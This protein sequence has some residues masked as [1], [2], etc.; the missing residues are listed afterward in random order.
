VVIQIKIERK[1][2]RWRGVV[3]GRVAWHGRPSPMPS[4]NG[5]GNCS[6]VQTDRTRVSVCG[7][8]FFF[9]KAINH[10]DK[11]WKILEEMEMRIN[12]SPR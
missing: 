8:F 7:S 10:C 12:N 11:D 4:T 9:F 5:Q 2:E 6:M 3:Q 1:R